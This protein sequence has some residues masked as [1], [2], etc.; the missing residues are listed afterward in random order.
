[1]NGNMETKAEHVPLGS[2]DSSV[3]LRTSRP[4]SDAA[5]PPQPPP[6]A[7]V[8]AFFLRRQTFLALS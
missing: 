4:K 1:M 8:A 6:K 7:R 3:W 2:C 5:P